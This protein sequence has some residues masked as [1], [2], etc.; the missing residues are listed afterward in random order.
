MASTFPLKI[1]NIAPRRRTSPTRVLSQEERDAAAVQAMLAD[2]SND[3]RSAIFSA[4]DDDDD[5]PT[6]CTNRVLT[7]TNTIRNREL[8]QLDDDNATKLIRWASKSF[9]PLSSLPMH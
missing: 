7:V 9:N 5:A 1:K 2:L 4:P 6:M 8:M 3:R